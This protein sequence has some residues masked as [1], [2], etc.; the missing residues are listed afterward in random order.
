MRAARTA[1]RV[2]VL[3]FDGVTLLDVSGPLEVLHQAGRQGHPYLPVLVSPH[4]GDVT[5]ASGPVLARTVRAAD[6]GAVDTLV[7]AGADLLAEDPA[8]P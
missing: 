5:T 2:A 7:V 3:V 4:G 6:A 1:H 8:D